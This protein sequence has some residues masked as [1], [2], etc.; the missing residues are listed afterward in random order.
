MIKQYKLITYNF[1]NYIPK[2]LCPRRLI[3]VETTPGKRFLIALNNPSGNLASSESLTAIT[4]VPLG[5]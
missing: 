4:V 2:I 1:Y 5:V 3:S